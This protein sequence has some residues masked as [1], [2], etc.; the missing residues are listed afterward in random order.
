MMTRPAARADLSASNE[1]QA[2]APEPGERS[3]L[4]HSQIVEAA[5]A[6]F[7]ENGYG[8]TSMDAI[9][10]RAGVS[11]RTV[12]GHFENK[13]ALFM[14]VMDRRCSALAGLDVT[15]GGL[16][17]IPEGLFHDIAD[18]DVA[19]T[20]SIVGA[21][22]L[23]LVLAEEPLRLFRIVVAEA[24]RF[25]E[26][27]RTFF[28]F[29]PQRLV[30]HLCAYLESAANAGRVTL[31]EPVEDIAWRFVCDLKDPRH[32]LMALG[33]ASPPNAAEKAQMVQRAVT[34][35]LHQIKPE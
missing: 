3:R 16:R 8:P 12:Y 29:G 7:L 24:E 21:R 31:G 34:R 1:Q 17:D 6:L 28:A 10:A 4:K 19:N 14:A 18:G 27:G 9:A 11:K 20:L 15:C 23:E 26:L 35:L 22:F 32:L 2:H 25:P 30:R 13:E 33:V 5:A